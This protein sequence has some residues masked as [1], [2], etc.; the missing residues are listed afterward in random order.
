M[1]DFLLAETQFKSNSGFLCF[2]LK[3]SDAIREPEATHNRTIQTSA[4]W[5]GFFIFFFVSM[6]SR[7]LLYCLAPVQ[8]VPRDVWAG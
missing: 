7:P 6:I 4:V 2:G 8:P 5:T 3:V 1:L